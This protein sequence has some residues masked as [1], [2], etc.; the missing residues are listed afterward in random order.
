MLQVIIVSAQGRLDV[1]IGCSA[2]DVRIQC[3]QLEDCFVTSKGIIVHMK[4]GVHTLAVQD[5]NQRYY[6]KF[7]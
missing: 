7:Y 2:I 6:G 4:I 1:E 3:K 5:E